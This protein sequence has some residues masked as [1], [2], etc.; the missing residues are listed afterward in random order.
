MQTTQPGPSPYLRRRS[1]DRKSI[2]RPRQFRYMFQMYNCHCCVKSS[3]QNITLE[4]NTLNWRLLANF[5]VV[6]LSFVHQP[7][8]FASATSSVILH[9][10]IIFFDISGL[11]SFRSRVF[12]LKGWMLSELH[13]LF[14]LRAFRIDCIHNDFDNFSMISCHLSTRCAC[15]SRMFF[16][17][18]CT[19]SKFLDF[20]FC[21]QVLS[22]F[23]TRA[24]MAN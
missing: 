5:C 23:A 7:P 14:L 21:S 16:A 3:F 8:F 1:S 24:T 10:L 2:K 12:V 4:K 6:V 20:L 15:R 17:T 13:P 11:A 18:S 9:D 19:I 22:G